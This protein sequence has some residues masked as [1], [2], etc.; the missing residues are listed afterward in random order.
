MHVC[1]IS[2]EYFSNSLVSLH[3]CDTLVGFIIKIEKQ[4]RYTVR[5]V[6]VDDFEKDPVCGLLDE[7]I[8][9]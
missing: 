5:V 4:P 3:P 7:A 6:C 8:N 9:L 2:V 1:S